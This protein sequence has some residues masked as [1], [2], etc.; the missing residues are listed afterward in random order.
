MK[1]NKSGSRRTF[2]KQL[3][4]LGAAAVLP[5]SNISGAEKKNSVG[6]AKNQM[7]LKVNPP[8][9]VWDVIVVGGGP[10]GCTAA[11]A[12]AREGAKTLL[13]EGTGILGGMGT[14]G[15]MNN[16]CPF[17][18]G[19]KI[20]YKG[21]AEKILMES[22][23][24]V[25]HISDSVND[26]VPIN[27]E[28]LKRT[29]DNFVT[30]SGANVLLFSSLAAV[31]MKNDSTVDR[32]IISNKAGLNAYKAK[33]YVDCTGDGD[34]SAWAGADY[35]FGDETGSLQSATLCFSYA[36]VNHEAYM[37]AR[38]ELD[39]KKP[40]SPIH[41]IVNSGKYPLVTDTHF[42]VKMAAESIL[43]FNAGHINNVNSTDPENLS[44]SMMKGRQLIHQMHEGLIETSPEIFGNSYLSGS[45][46]LLGLRESRRIIG[47]YVFNVDDWLARRSFD[48]EIGRNSY[49]IDVHKKGRKR[50][51]RYN[52][53]ESH[54]I[55]F[56]ILTPEKLANVLTAGR[57][58][59][60]DEY[61]FGSLRVMPV[62]L[63]TG[64]AAGLAAA[65]VSKM[66]RP[67][68]HQ[69]DISLLRKRLK[70][71]GQNIQ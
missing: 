53:G 18:D 33:V 58:V 31:E 35:F 4:L 7:S 57:C 52:K 12:A 1:L 2:V 42:N 48:D 29:Y 61:A 38:Y 37:K 17:T 66:G 56:R 20:I 51:P 60:C 16:W 41:K 24:G 69:T 34:L 45:G 70:E 71:E 14:A 6:K 9:E 22:K 3:G 67:D 63:V 55:P 43:M 13:I 30:Q 10:A 32:I 15:H 39:P 8:K 28:Y 27:T 36:N 65:L 19:T 25:P 5:L 11:I 23:K 46:A 44:A 64:E 54:G 40:E 59:S 68:V 50:Y 21:L 49:Y 47:D 26:W 62:C